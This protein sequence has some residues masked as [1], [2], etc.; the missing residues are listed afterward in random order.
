MLRLIIVDDEKIIRDS[1]SQLVDWAGLGIQL[2]GTCKDGVEAY[3]MIIDEYPDIVIT[4]I[5]MPG[6]N[7]LELIER[8]KEIDSSIEFVILSGYQEFEFAK[9]AMQFG[10]QYY[11]LKPCCESEIYEVIEKVKKTCKKKKDLQAIHSEHEELKIKMESLAI[12]E[13]I[14]ESI[15]TANL[16]ETVKHLDRERPST[17]LYQISIYY[18]L[19]DHIPLFLHKAV[20]YLKPHTINLMLYVEN[21]LIIIL[22]HSNDIDYKLLRTNL[23]N[24]TYSNQPV[25]L[26][27]FGQCFSSLGYLVNELIPRLKRYSKIYLVNEHN[28]IQE[29]Y[30]YA[31]AFEN[32][33]LLLQYCE[34]D[35][36]LFKKE[37]RN[38]FKMLKE[39]E[40]ARIYSFRLFIGLQKYKSAQNM[41]DN[42]VSNYFQK[43][44]TLGTSNEILEF[45]MDV[46]ITLSNSSNAETHY[47]SFILKT[48]EYVKEHMSD[49]NLS[50][51]SIAENCLFM[52]V[53]Y[54][55]RAFSKETG[56][57]FSTYLTN[58]RMEKAKYLL[59]YS[60]EE[61]IYIV[62]EQVGCGNPQ[63]FSQIFKK[64]VGVSPT[65]YVQMCQKKLKGE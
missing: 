19:I 41:N 36:G 65:T 47:K 46:A 53:D 59:H 7:G 29:I 27:S 8:S 31:S 17:P 28:A 4:D 2:I 1:I 43:L 23:E 9:K 14:I 35:I 48:M 5:K 58:I 42:L 50:L 39:V 55:S 45:T 3:N 44:I 12:K 61:K 33:Q 60:D 30:N 37:L 54:V 32:V 16:T 38:T 26:S 25:N 52:N 49:Q 62:A 64:S 24:I 18:L 20:E 22:P 11:L 15:T 10:V 13:G 40:L 21:T 6:L 34:H 51:K 63:Y 56:E 57:K